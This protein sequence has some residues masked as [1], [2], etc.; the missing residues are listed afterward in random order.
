MKI[1]HFP[2]HSHVGAVRSAVRFAFCP[3]MHTIQV[4]IVAHSLNSAV[5]VSIAA[6]WNANPQL[7]KVG[8]DLSKCLLYE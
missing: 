8:S 6:G 7:A 2:R 1:P 5:R 4:L 3:P